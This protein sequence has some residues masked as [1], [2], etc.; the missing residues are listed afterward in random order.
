PGVVP[1]G[2]RSGRGAIALK[3]GTSYGFRDAWA[4]GVTREFIVGVWAGRADGTPSPDRLGRDAAAPVLQKVFDLLPVIPSPV[5]AAGPGD[6]PPALLRR[7]D[8][9]PAVAGGIRMHDPH[10]LRLVYPVSRSTIARDG[11]RMPLGLIAAG[12]RRPLSWLVDGRPL[13]TGAATRDAEWLPERAGQ[14][15]ITVLDADGRSDSAV[16]DVR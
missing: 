4:F 14:V 16:I 9:A 2:A 8:S 5:T 7:L 1:A 13:V 12:G 15:R 11:E 6:S 10:R 3:T